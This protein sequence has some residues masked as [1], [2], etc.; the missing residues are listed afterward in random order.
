[1]NVVFAPTNQALL[2]TILSRRPSASP[3][4][5][6]LNAATL[7]G[8]FDGR[9]ARMSDA[10][11][12][13]H[14]K[15]HQVTPATFVC[16]HLCFGV[17]CGFHRSDDDPAD[18][19]PDAW[20]DRCEAAFEHE[21]DW[22]ASNEPEISVVC[23]G[24]YEEARAR[25]DRVPAPLLPGQLTVSAA[26]FADLAHQ[27]CER[28]KVRQ[29]AARRAWPPFAYS[30]RWHYD[31]EARTIRFSGSPAEAAV[32]ADV[33]IAGSFS[34]HTNTWMW[35]WAN[36]AYPDSERAKVAPLRVFGEVRGIEK[37]H[38]GQWAAEEIDGWEVTQIAA[39]LVGAAAIYRAPMDHLYIF[40]L[41]DNFRALYR[42]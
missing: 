35:A 26:E 19:W 18:P 34:T 11:K 20:C 32:I 40:M 15:Q 13:V 16:R 24:C 42:S 23:T 27:A 36:E 29:E 33:T 9:Q 12:T 7:A 38:S 30:K 37:F 21:G 2:L 5:S 1:M 31:R 25:N 6:Q 39:D 10:T 22:N 17:A 4:R 14:C 28:S 41:L 8:Q 3:W